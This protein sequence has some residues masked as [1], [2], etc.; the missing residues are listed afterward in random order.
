MDNKF[1]FWESKHPYSWFSCRPGKNGFLPV[2]KPLEYLPKKFNII[3]E[4]LEK[5]KITQNNVI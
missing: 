2:D 4:L 1:N 3:N 5:M